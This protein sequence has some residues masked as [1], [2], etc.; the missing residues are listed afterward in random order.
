MS[1][2]KPTAMIMAAQMQMINIPYDIREKF[3]EKLFIITSRISFLISVIPS[4]ISLL[5]FL[6]LSSHFFSHFC[7]FF[8]Y[9]LISSHISVISFLISP[10]IITTFSFHSFFAL[11]Y[12]FQD[13]GQAQNSISDLFEKIADI[14][15]KSSQSERM[16][17][18]ALLCCAALCYVI[19]WSKVQYNTI[20]SY[21]VTC[22][23]V[24]H[25]V[26]LC[27]TALYSTVPY[28]ANNC[29]VQVK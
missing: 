29:S 24:L 10:L 14:K 18:L 9:P 13:I 27:C 26:I 28:F 22:H 7:H 21:A 11:F 8:S 6:F 20:T 1:D 16:V 5:P 3:D 2:D 17:R 23:A 15:A 12:F 25:Y 4:V 19:L